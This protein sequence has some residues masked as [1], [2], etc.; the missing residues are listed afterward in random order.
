M[1]L[2]PW[3]IVGLSPRFRTINCTTVGKRRDIFH[4]DPKKW[5]FVNVSPCFSFS[6]GLFSVSIL[7]FGGVKYALKFT[8]GKTNMRPENGWL[9]DNPLHFGFRKALFSRGK[10]AVSFREGVFGN[11]ES[12]PSCSWPNSQVLKVVRVKITKADYCEP[13]IH[14][15]SQ[16]DGCLLYNLY[17][18][19]RKSSI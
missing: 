14:K 2:Q 13:W 17:E 11:K 4:T 7:V 8:L 1:Y 18:L 12:Q 3:K 15:W 9:W 16:V 5:W 19:I 10:L 6:K